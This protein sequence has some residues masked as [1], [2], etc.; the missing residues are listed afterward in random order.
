M[1]MKKTFIILGIMVFL[2]VTVLVVR[3]NNKVKIDEWS[4]GLVVEKLEWAEVVKGNGSLACRY[5]I[6]EDEYDELISL[7]KTVK[8]DAKVGKWEEDGWLNDY[9]LAIQYEQK[10]WLFNCVDNGHITIV[11]DIY[12]TAAYYG[13]ENANLIVDCPELWDYIV[14]TV[15][16]KAKQCDY[17][18]KVGV[19]LPAGTYVI[20]LGE[21]SE[22]D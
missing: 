21:G 7:L 1:K 18:V 4:S 8:A 10:I 20:Q 12:E 13:D 14:N 6:S 2:V 17:I 19:H 3:N 9:S 5:T 22:A 16:T 11:F 15:D